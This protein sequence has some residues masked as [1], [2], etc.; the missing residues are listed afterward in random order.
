M[1]SRS[2]RSG[3]ASIAFE[4]ASHAAGGGRA[5]ISRSHRRS[6][7]AGAIGGG[8]FGLRLHRLVDE[9]EPLFGGL[10]GWSRGARSRYS[11]SLREN[12][13]SFGQRCGR[14]RRNR[15][16][17]DQRDD[18][19]KRHERPLFRGMPCSIRLALACQGS[20]MLRRFRR[21]DTRA[22]GGLQ[23]RSSFTTCPC[24]SVR[25]KSRPA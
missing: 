8:R 6:D 20:S 10:V 3:R 4:S 23:A 19:P 9:R 7:A 22:T 2:S 16:Q 11:A 5:S 1:P 13:S 12:G 17:C 24:T 25:R 15:R 14:G 21:A 18:D